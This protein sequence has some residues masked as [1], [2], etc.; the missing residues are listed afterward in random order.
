[1]PEESK[2]TE[3]LEQKQSEVKFT[4]EEL[5]SI[6]DIQKSYTEVTGKLHWQILL[7]ARAIETQCFIAAS[8]QYGAHQNKRK[9]WGNSML[10]D[11]WGEIMG[12]KTG[13]GWLSHPLT[14]NR[15]HQVRK[16]IILLV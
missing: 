16:S 11:P 3:K 14:L 4:E 7:Q 8:A 6:Q 10:I 2:L 12:Q 15:L 13:L 9:T 5:K 1:M